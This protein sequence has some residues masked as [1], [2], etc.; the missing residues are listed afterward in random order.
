MNAVN[1]ELV[2]AGTTN[3]T[4]LMITDATKNEPIDYYITVVTG[5]LKVGIGSVHAN[6][7]P[8]PAGGKIPIR[9][10]NGQLHFVAG[11]GADTFV[12]T[13]A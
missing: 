10:F 4:P 3:P 9:C 8:Y 12:T 2:T 1:G 7:Y 13:T 5:T 6:A 11:S